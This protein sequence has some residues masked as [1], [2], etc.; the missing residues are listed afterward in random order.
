MK[1]RN[2]PKKKMAKPKSPQKSSSASVVSRQI[3]TEFSGPLPHPAVLSEYEHIHQGFAERIVALAEEE[4]AHRRKLQ[5]KAL[6]GD[7]ETQRQ[8]AREIRLGQIFAFSIGVI[9]ILSGAYTATH[10]AELAGG[11]IGTGGVVALVS[12]F[13]YGRKTPHRE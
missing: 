7:L 10:G 9:V 8:T 3:H 4:A 5:E 11:L 1:N 6:E 2:I 13:I 12:V